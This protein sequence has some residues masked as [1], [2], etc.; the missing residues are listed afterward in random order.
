MKWLTED[1]AEQAMI[2][3]ISGARKNIAILAGTNANQVRIV[4]LQGGVIG[5][6]ERVS[7]RFY[8]P[9]YVQ[10]NGQSQT[11]E[12]CSAIDRDWAIIASS[13]PHGTVLPLLFWRSTRHV[14]GVAPS[15]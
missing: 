10:D 11:G 6:V 9:L 2:V 13:G 8:S 7:V 15:F 4:R 5:R 14:L 3:S 12:N 1:C